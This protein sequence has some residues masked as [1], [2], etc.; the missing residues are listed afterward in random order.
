MAFKLSNKQHK[1]LD[2]LLEQ[3]LDGFASGEFSKQEIT[4]LIAHIITAGVIDNESEL[5]A[6][7]EDPAAMEM[8]K[9]LASATRP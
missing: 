4:E 1:Q 6:W 9:E 7:L 2:A 3:L 5:K 8:W